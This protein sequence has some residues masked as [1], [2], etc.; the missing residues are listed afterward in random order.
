MYSLENAKTRLTAI[1]ILALI[2]SLNNS[3][4]GQAGVITES[5]QIN[6]V[7]MI[8][9]GFKQQVLSIL[10]NNSFVSIKS[11]ENKKDEQ[12][13]EIQPEDENAMTTE[14]AQESLLS[15]ENIGK[16]YEIRIEEEYSRV[17]LKSIPILSDKRGVS[18][19]QLK[20]EEQLETDDTCGMFQSQ[21]FREIREFLVFEG[22]Q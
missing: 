1:E 9:S 2:Y 6:Q 10:K 21:A 5:E 3:N 18:Y 12:N 22:L 17:V 20:T 19:W 8:F 4:N 16:Q 14:D 11:I 15:L 13:G 7:N